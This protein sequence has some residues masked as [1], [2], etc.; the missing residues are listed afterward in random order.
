MLRA[1]S[2][3][4]AVLAILAAHP[5]SAQ[6]AASQR[7]GWQPAQGNAALRPNTIQ[8]NKPVAMANKIVKPV[9]LSADSQRTALANIDH[10]IS[11]QAAELSEK[12]KSVLPDELAMLTKTNGWTTED[13]QALVG[14]LRAVIPRPSTKPG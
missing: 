13:Q 2:S 4:L 8:P 3:V 9:P 12:L 7:F 10:H 5:V 11:Q 6:K 14:A 1:I